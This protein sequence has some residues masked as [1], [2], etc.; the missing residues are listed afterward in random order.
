MEERQVELHS[1][2]ILAATSFEFHVLL[3]P[4]MVTMVDSLGYIIP[5]VKTS[6]VGLRKHQ[7]YLSWYLVHL[8]QA[9]FW[10]IFL[11]QIWVSE[12]RFV[13]EKVLAV[14]NFN[15]EVTFKNLL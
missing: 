7:A 3:Q 4:I 2:L 5:R 11:Q 15:L 8:C 6:V 1:N 13:P 10:V 12:S 9:Q 14:I